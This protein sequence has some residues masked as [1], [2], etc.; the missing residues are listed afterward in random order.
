MTRRP[1]IDWPPISLWLLSQIKALPYSPSLRWAFYRILDN[2]GLAKNDWDRFK[3]VSS[4]WRKTGADGWAP[5]TLTDSIRSAVYGG[6]GPVAERSWRKAMIDG[7]PQSTVY[8]DLDFYVEVWFESEAM[9]GQFEYYLGKPYRITM[10]PFRGDYTI[11]M[12]WETAKHIDNM[13]EI[14]KKVIILYFGDADE[15]GKI[16]PESALKDIR[17]WCEND[18]EFVFGGL[19]V[20]QAVDLKLPE[21]F[22]RPGQWQWDA[23]PDKAAG[24]IIMDTLKASVD[25]A[26]LKNAVKKAEAREKKWRTT[27]WKLLEVN[28]G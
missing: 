8:N 27:A 17:E 10:R 3:A 20:E 19:S 21:N 16:I 24:K 14:E 12:K 5:D 13:C 9:A 1:N 23:L 26:A 6:F 7:S 11:P 2:F 28:D 22:E 15:K 25:V 18:F 4:R